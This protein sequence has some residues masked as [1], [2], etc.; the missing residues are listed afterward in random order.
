MKLPTGVNVLLGFAPYIA[1]FLVMR[2][3]AV[4]VGLWAALV[5]AVFNAGRDWALTGSLKLL[6]VGTVLLFAALAIFTAAARW[7]WT[8]MAVRLAVDGGLLAIILGSLAV[9]RPFTLQYARER[10]PEQYWQAPL[11]I[12]VNRLIT[13][14]WAAAFTALV[15]AHAAVV[16]VPGVPLSLDIAVTILALALALWFSTW[17]PARVRKQANLTLEGDS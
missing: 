9:G 17:Y 15:A 13:G 3:V 10:V 1:F 16:F 2:A 8:V 6:E 12:R 14:A 11:F 4:D 7:D 5:I